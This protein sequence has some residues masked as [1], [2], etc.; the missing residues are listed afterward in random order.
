MLE[1]SDPAR[2]VELA[3]NLECG[4]MAI[5]LVAHESLTTHISNDDGYGVFVAVIWLWS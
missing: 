2:G 3:K 5:P 4:L 1:R